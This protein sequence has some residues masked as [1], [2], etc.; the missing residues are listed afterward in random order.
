MAV[1]PQTAAES[2][3]PNPARHFVGFFGVRE[4]VLGALLFAARG[5]V[6]Q[7]RPLAALG[8]LADMG[9]TAVLLRELLG[10]R[11][12]EPGALALLGTGVSGSAAAVAFWLETR[13]ADPGVSAS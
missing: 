2:S 12:T 7:L 1:E 13:R 11:R 3:R 10:R 4:L 9:D 6:R 5:D 8:A